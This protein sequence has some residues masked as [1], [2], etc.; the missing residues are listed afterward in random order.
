MILYT[1]DGCLRETLS[2][3]QGVKPLVLYY[4]HCRM[5]MDT[6]QGKLDSSQFDLRNTELFCIPEVTSVFFSFCDSV[7]G[8]SLKFHQANWG[9]LCLWLGKRNCSALNARES[10]L[11]LWR[12][13]S[14]MGFLK[15]RQE[16]GVYSRTTVG[17]S[18][19][20]CSFFIKV[21]T[22]VLVQWTPPESKVALAG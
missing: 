9:S 7:P 5:F 16:P 13:K 11:I 18:T 10:D 1:C 8:D 3:L 22:S 17:M 4:V 19:Q 21:K 12:E 2:F 6:M 14:L 20:N 15:L